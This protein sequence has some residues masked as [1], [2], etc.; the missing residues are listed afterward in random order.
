MVGTMKA[1]TKVTVALFTV[2]IL[3]ALVIG[4]MALGRSIGDDAGYCTADAD[5]ASNPG[6]YQCFNGHG[7]DW[8]EQR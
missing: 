2:G 4:S 5:Q 3:L 7:E 1:N 6:L 8:T